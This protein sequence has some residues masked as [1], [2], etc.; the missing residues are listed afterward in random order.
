MVEER[1]DTLL[2]EGINSGESIPVTPE[3]WE[4]K[5]RKLTERHRETV[6]TPR[7]CL[8]IWTRLLATADESF[9]LAKIGRSEFDR[10]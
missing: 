7:L 6:V 4:M 5:K 9:A 2:R 1:L 10:R 8:F 3:Y